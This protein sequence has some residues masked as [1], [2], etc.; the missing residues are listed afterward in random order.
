MRAASAVCVGGT[1]PRSPI[2]SG[3]ATMP[4]ASPPTPRR[5]RLRL[6]SPTTRV[7]WAPALRDARRV[8][9]RFGL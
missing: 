6:D 9:A 5:S 3:T 8:R 7:W 4:V 1:A 2:W